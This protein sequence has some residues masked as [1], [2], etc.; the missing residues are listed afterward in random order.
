MAFPSSDCPHMFVFFDTS[1]LSLTPTYSSA[2]S[3]SDLLFDASG[4]VKL[5]PD[6]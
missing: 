2:I 1:D 5:V 4:L 3:T 6:S